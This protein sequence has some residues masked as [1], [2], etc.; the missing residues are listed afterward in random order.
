M[1]L[2]SFGIGPLN[3]AGVVID[4]E[5]FACFYLQDLQR[6]IKNGRVTL[7]LAKVIAVKNSI[8]VL[9]EIVLRIQLIQ[10]V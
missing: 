7:G 8:K 10:P 4:K 3:M 9:K 2:Q 6:I 1:S 5:R